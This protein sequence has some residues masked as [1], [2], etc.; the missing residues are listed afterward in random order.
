M[1]IRR[2]QQLAAQSDQVPGTDERA[3]LVPLLGLAGEVGS[4]LSEY[5]KQLRDGQAHL[6]YRDE[7]EED[8]GDLL[9]Y[10]A[11]VASK[12]GLDL[13]EIAERNLEKVHERWPE[14][15]EGRTLLGE[16]FHLFD[17]DF[18]SNE[19]LPR[20]FEAAFR[21]VDIADNRRVEVQVNGV[22]VGDSLTDNWPDDDGYRFH[23]VFHFAYA[24][25]LGWSPRMRQLLK[26]KR[27]SIPKMDEVEDGA[28]AGIAEELVSH[29]IFAYAREHNFLDGVGSIDYH[30]LKT[31][32]SVVKGWEIQARSM[33][34]WESAILQGFE[35]WRQIRLN[36]GGRVQAN[37]PNRT[38]TFV[39]EPTPELPPRH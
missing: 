23:D 16:G 9:W 34:D 4:L 32:K 36:G 30:L 39:A 31:I 11:N 1:E 24:A 27:K 38:L 14:M 21:E 3:V 20:Q 37:L 28:R 17:S 35:S 29:L 8:L 33:S 13:G 7:V 19:Q 22:Q 5:K 25:V 18:P 15:N 10:V 26:C 6:R 12:F 2:Y